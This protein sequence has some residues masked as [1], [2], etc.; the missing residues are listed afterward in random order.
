MS[1]DRL[2]HRVDIR[3]KGLNIRVIRDRKVERMERTKKSTEPQRKFLPARLGLPRLGGRLTLGMDAG[4]PE[5]Y[6]VSDPL[7]APGIATRSKGR[8]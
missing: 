4:N 7:G 1:I 8:Y 6:F 2:F 3:C 5:R